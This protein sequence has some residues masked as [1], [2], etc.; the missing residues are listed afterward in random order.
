MLEC[1]VSRRRVRLAIGELFAILTLPLLVHAVIHFLLPVGGFV[2]WFLPAIYGVAIIF[3]VVLCVRVLLRSGP[4]VVFNDNGIE[5][6]R[7]ALGV[8]EW[9]DI[10]RV[11]IRAMHG[12]EFLSIDVENPEKYLSRLSWWCRWGSRSLVRQG[13]PAI[14]ISFTLMDRS[15]EQVIEFI[16]RNH[17]DVI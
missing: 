13:Y 10:R 12:A 5:D 3:A 16:R 8:I 7:Q 17:A 6:R 4:Q 14:A 15:L 9:S 2:R 11:S 1:H